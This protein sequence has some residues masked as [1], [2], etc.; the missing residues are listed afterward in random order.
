MG[1]IR[2]WP[3]YLLEALLA[4]AS[5]LACRQLLDWLLIAMQLEAVRPVAYVVGLAG[6]VL[7]ALRI[8]AIVNRWLAQKGVE[9]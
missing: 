1:R 3:I 8:Q 7:L 4:F 9:P 2:N 6:F 5:A